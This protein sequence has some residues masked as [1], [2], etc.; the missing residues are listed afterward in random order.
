MMA[1]PKKD[2]EAINV[3]LERELI[4]QLDNFRRGQPDLPGRPEG[5]RRLLLIGLRHA[6]TLPPATTRTPA[7]KRPAAR[8]DMRQ[9][10]RM[11]AA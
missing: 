1:R 7:R 11:G 2:S 8:M 6:P 3:R 10:A 5:I 9:P 4:Q